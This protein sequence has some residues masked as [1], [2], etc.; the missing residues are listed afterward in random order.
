MLPESKLHQSYFSMKAAITSDKAHVTIQYFASN[1]SNKNTTIYESRIV[2][3]ALKDMI[4][5]QSRQK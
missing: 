3:T 4:I 5:A 2:G 1:K